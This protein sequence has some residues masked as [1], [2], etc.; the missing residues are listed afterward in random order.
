MKNFIVLNLMAKLREG[1]W[2]W[3]SNS[4]FTSKCQQEFSV[5]VHLF[6]LSSKKVHCSLWTT[7]SKWT[8]KKTYNKTFKQRRQI[9]QEI[10]K[11][12]LLRVSLHASLVVHW[13]NMSR[14]KVVHIPNTPNQGWGGETLSRSI[15]QV[16]SDIECIFKMR[17]G[18]ISK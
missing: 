5:V 6:V 9:F 4:L 13:L 10:C 16:S 11:Q 1:I 12:G 14:F 8:Y 17:S 18:N 7:C 15:S 2:E 3:R